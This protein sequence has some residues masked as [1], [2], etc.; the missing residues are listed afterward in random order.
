M[1][2]TGVNVPDSTTF[3]NIV[4]TF[5]EANGFTTDR[6]TDLSGT[7]PDIEWLAHKGDLYFSIATYPT[8]GSGSDPGGHVHAWMNTGYSSAAAY[9]AQPGAAPSAVITGGITYPLTTYDL[10]TGD[11]YLYIVVQTSTPGV[12]RHIWLCEVDKLGMTYDGGQLGAGTLQQISTSSTNFPYA[13]NHRKPLEYTNSYSSG[14][15]RFRFADG[16]NTSAVNNWLHCGNTASGTHR[17]EGAIGSARHLA[18]S[19]FSWY[20]EERA[21]WTLGRKT[22]DLVIPVFVSTVSG[23]L[24]LAGIVKDVLNM[25]IQNYVPRQL[26]NVD[27]VDYRVYPIVSKTDSWD[28][29]GSATQSSGYRGLAYKV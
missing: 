26:V 20:L 18:G 23:K 10:H 9:N 14:N 19:P 21:V 7:N 27:G 3:W 22:T 29:N 2:Q 13:V 4:K 5:A 28:V 17:L 16:A 12:F 1:H 11:N 25:S 15:T 24:S 6:F 8:E